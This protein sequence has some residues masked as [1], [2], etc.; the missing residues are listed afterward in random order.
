[1]QYTNT[2][3]IHFSRAPSKESR[4][5]DPKK[6]KNLRIEMQ[7]KLKQVELVLCNRSP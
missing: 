3:I 6:K 2:S 7:L 5:E 1:M 4:D